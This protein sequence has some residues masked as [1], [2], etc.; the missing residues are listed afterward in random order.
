MNKAIVIGRHQGEVPGFE[1]VEQ[2]NITFPF[3]KMG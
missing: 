1:V 2:R 3:L